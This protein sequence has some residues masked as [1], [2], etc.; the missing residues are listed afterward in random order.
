M[1]GVKPVLVELVFSWGRE[2]KSQ[3]EVE[4]RTSSDSVERK[5]RRRERE[6]RGMGESK[7]F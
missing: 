2:K 1:R 7:L 6:A 3:I 4:K 5:A